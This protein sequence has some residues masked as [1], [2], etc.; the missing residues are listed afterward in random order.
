MTSCMYAGWMPHLPA[1]PR[2]LGI[3]LE[4]RKPPGDDYEAHRARPRVLRN[5]T[6][7]PETLGRDTCARRPEGLQA[8]SG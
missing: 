3:R 5:R 8:G 4:P 7:A 1:T 2:P 6:S